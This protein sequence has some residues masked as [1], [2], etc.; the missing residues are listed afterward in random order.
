MTVTRERT[1]NLGRFGLQYESEKVFISLNDE[2][3]D[4]NIGALLGRAQE[5]LD[6]EVAKIEAKYA[7]R[8]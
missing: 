5:L 7:G 4:G 1:V 3:T 6:V 8:K 2:A